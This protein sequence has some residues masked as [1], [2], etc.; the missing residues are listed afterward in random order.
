M[1]HP[2]CVDEWLKNWNRVCPLCKASISRTGTRAQSHAR[3]ENQQQPLLSNLE[4]GESS[5][6]GSIRLSGDVEDRNNASTVVLSDSSTL[7]EDSGAG[8]NT[9]NAT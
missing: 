1:F 3:T 8:T 2:S 6:Y 5:I 9:N 4:S 7:E